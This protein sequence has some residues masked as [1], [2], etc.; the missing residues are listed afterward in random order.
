MLKKCRR[1]DWMSRRTRSA[2]Q[3]LP[4]QAGDELPG[5]RQQIAEHVRERLR[6]RLLH[7]QHLDRV[8]PDDQVVAVALDGG[9]RDEVV[10]VRVVCQRRGRRARRVV[11]HQP[12]E[13]PER[14]GLRQPR[15]AARRRAAPR[16]PAPCGAA[17]RSARSRSASSSAARAV[18]ATASRGALRAGRR[19]ARATDVGSQRRSAARTAGPG[20]DR[21][22]T[23]RSRRAFR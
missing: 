15:E 12:A 8:P 11:V 21:R 3:S 10:E 6:R 14:L 5:Q 1:R 16:G 13:E 2:R 22:R 20:S 19:H 7:R 9:V 4:F 17:C 18:G 23:G